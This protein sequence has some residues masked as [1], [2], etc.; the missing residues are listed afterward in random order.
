MGVC[1]CDKVK[2]RTFLHSVTTC[3]VKRTEMKVNYHATLTVEENRDSSPNPGGLLNFRMVPL[4]FTAKSRSALPN[5]DV[6]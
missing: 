3:A 2:I 4:H 1:V 5:S 6:V